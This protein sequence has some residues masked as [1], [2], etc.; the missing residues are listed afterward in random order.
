MTQGAV[1]HTATG[2]VIDLIDGFPFQA[3]GVVSRILLKAPTGSVTSFAFDAGQDLSEHT[4][5]YEAMIVVVQGQGII[6]IDGKPHTLD[7]GQAIRLP[8]HVPH[9][10]RAEQPFKMLLTML[11]SPKE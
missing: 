11:R 1:S 9:A 5:P 8:A 4:C 6:T 2:D 10:V 3:D 7:A